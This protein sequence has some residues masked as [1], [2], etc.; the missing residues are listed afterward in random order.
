[1]PFESI[2]AVASDHMQ[3][4]ACHAPIRTIRGRFELDGELR[5]AELGVIC[6]LGLNAQALQQIANIFD[7]QCF[8]A[9]LKLAN[10]PPGSILE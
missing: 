9:I 8:L 5:K 3:G 7:D 10:F 1:M 2:P 4:A 6:L